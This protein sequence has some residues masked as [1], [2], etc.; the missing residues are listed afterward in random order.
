MTFQPGSRWVLGV[1]G[2]NRFPTNGE[3]G[4]TATATSSELAANKPLT[5]T[6]ATWTEATRT[7]TKTGLFAEYAF[8]AGDRVY[9]SG[10]TGATAGTYLVESRTSANAI[11][12]QTSIGAAANGQT[13]IAGTLSPAS[14][15]QQVVTIL[16]IFVHVAAAIAVTACDGLGTAIPGT[17]ITLTAAGDIGWYPFGPT[18]IRYTG[19][20]VG[21]TCGAGATASLYYFKG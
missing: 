7:L 13:D 17:S 14:P 16:G 1:A 19:G 5:I 12:L 2:A 8:A 9:I 20:N 21:I 6:A 18:G 3:G 10:G 11:V 15:S 4:A